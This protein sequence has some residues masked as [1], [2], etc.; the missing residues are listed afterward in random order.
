MKFRI[1]AF[2]LILVVIS[3]S[4]FLQE[5]EA[6]SET[7]NRTL[8][9]SIVLEEGKKQ[10]IITGDFQ[11]QLEELMKDQIIF[12]E[13]QIITQAK[14]SRLFGSKRIHYNNY[15]LY[16]E[17][18]IIASNYEKENRNKYLEGFL[19]EQSKT[20]DEIDVSFYSY[21]FRLEQYYCSLDNNENCSYEEN[22]YNVNVVNLLDKADVI[23]N[24]DHHLNAESLYVIFSD[25]MDKLGYNDYIK[26]LEYYYDLNTTKEVIGSRDIKTNF[27]FPVTGIVYKPIYA[28]EMQMEMNGASYDFLEYYDDRFF[29]SRVPVEGNLTPSN[30]N[31]P[32]EKMFNLENEYK[33]VNKH[34]QL[35]DTV[36]LIGDSQTCLFSNFFY[37]TFKETHSLDYRYQEFNITEYVLKYN[38]DHVI[39]LGN[40]FN[41]NW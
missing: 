22:D 19:N 7:E 29:N 15:F 32:K 25:V 34:A 33:V 12:R 9:N 14:L 24:G 39:Y 35:D 16:D 17:G 6:K 20:F 10:G 21:I 28:E 27:N 1:I 30:C 41:K 3:S 23:I 26:P 37:K 8:K 36:L 4:F 5:F 31:S 2:L 18:I 11:S 38:I 40:S 13:D